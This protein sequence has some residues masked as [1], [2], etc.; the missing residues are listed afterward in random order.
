VS[1]QSEPLNKGLGAY[2]DAWDALNQSYYGGHPFLDSRFTEL[3]LTHFAAGGERLFIHRSGGEIDGLV[4]LR[5]RGLGIWRQ[6]VP[7]QLQ[8][9]PLLIP[10]RGVIDTL[11]TSLPPGA[12]LIEFLN[13]DP[14]FVPP[15][16]MESRSGCLVQPHAVTTRVSLSGSFET[17][18]GERSENLVKNIR[19]YS[20]RVS[21][22][23]G[24]EEL[25]ILSDPDAMYDAVRRYSELESAG[26][27]GERGTAVGFGNAQ[28]PFYAELLASYAR[29][30]Q[31]RVFEYWIGGKLAAS[32]LMID[33]A[34]MTVIL[35]TAYDEQLSRFAPGRLL[36]HEILK[37]EFGEGSHERLDFYTNAT[38]DQLAWAT[39]QRVVSHVSCFRHPWQKRLYTYYR[40]INASRDRG[41][42]GA[43]GQ[44]PSSVEIHDEISALPKAC[45]K[46]FRAAERESFDLGRDWF[47][48]LARTA[49]PAGVK[50]RFYVL[51]KGASIRC[52]LPVLVGNKRVSA[53][54]TF[55]SSL[56]RPLFAE[57]VCVE[58]VATVLRRVMRDIKPGAIR[59]D[60]M[61]P[62]HPTYGMVFAALR[63]VGLKTFRFFDFGNWYLP[64]AGCSFAE[65]AA[66][67]PSRIQNTVRRREKRFLAAGRGRLEIIEGGEGLDAAIAAWNRIYLSSWKVPE[68][69]PEFVPGLIRLCARRGWL[70][71]GLAYYDGEPI[72]AQLWIVA[73]GRAAIYKLAYSQSHAPL[74]GGTLL[75]A[76]LMRHVLDVDRVR[77]VDYLVGDD[78][79]KK[80]WMSHRRER[81]GIV[82]YNVFTPRGAM[83]YGIQGMGMLL[84]RGKQEPACNTRAKRGAA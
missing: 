28:G 70:R 30:G 60:A 74:S 39:A 20:N 79:Y 21:K 41:D 18:W 82:A 29:S 83:G 81:W 59:L 24:S 19:R 23:G 51:L 52:V 67:L 10:S 2:R 84:R 40:R 45:E 63:Q 7:A 50:S 66:Q 26:W 73:D 69:Y 46:L 13:Q 61:D 57:D 55:Y 47:E 6:F 64:A 3:M 44:E 58:E 22:E 76:H 62:D 9:S 34:G 38:Q 49:I 11:F 48:L 32:R 77:E 78:A 43:A 53:L 15:D 12:W 17:Y 35:K 1:W 80:D 42:A 54:T 31:G 71:L 36:L 16:F 8:A 33:G 27:K 5:H 75:T 72:A 25:R 14:D 56:Y 65:Y 4:I 68:P 37:H